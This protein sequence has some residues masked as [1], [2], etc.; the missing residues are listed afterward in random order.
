MASENASIPS[1]LLVKHPG[2]FDVRGRESAFNGDAGPLPRFFLDLLL[3]STFRSRPSSCSLS[4]GSPTA[5][6]LRF[7]SILPVVTLPPASTLRP[8]D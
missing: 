1:S 4:A 5:R 8:P 7:P 6:I 3:A 2:C